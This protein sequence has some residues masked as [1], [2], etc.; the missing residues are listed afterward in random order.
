VSCDAL[1]TAGRLDGGYY[2]YDEDEEQ[3]YKLLIGFA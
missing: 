2:S 1:I 3:R